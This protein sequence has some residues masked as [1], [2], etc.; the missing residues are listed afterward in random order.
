M[1]IAE[2]NVATATKS[3][4]EARKS[5]T[6]AEV[7][8]RQKYLDDV[9]RLAQ[10]YRDQAT[11]L[12]KAADQKAD[13]NRTMLPAMPKAPQKPFGEF[14]KD[15]HKPVPVYNVKDDRTRTEQRQQGKPKLTQVPVPMADPRKAG[16]HRAAGRPVSVC[17]LGPTKTSPQTTGLLNQTVGSFKFSADAVKA[18][19]DPI[20][21]VTKLAE[22]PAWVTGLGTT[23]DTSATN[24]GT[25]FSTGATNMGTALTTAGTTVGTSIETGGS[26]AGSNIASAMIGAGNTAA[27]AIRAAV[28][29]I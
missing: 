2:T 17:S 11:K 29:N 10:G 24:F 20:P 8:A 6:K 23:L 18:S 27:A 9:R 3:L 4:A 28:S 22:V 15:D 14:I 1:N 26:T 16:A 12:I 25:V 7:A 21:S 5:G 13:E 19:S